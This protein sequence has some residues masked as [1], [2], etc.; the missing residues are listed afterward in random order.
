MVKEK[1]MKLAMLVNTDK[2]LD[3]VV[4]ITKSAVSK[5]HEVIIFAMD[6]GEKLLENPVYSEL[7]KLQ[8]VSMSFCD[9]NAQQLGIKKDVIPSEIVCGSQFN[10]ATI[11][12]KADRVIVL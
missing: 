7:C 3:T 11:V 5:G 6:E 12:H 8:G 2:N 1:D 4:G 9:H 10:N